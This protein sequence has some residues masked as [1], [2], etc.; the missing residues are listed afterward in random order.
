M[1]IDVE[2]WKPFRIDSLFTIIKGRRLTKED[3]EPGTTPFITATMENNGL[4]ALIGLPPFCPGNSLSVVYNGNGVSTAFYQPEPFFPCDDVNCFVPNK[5]TEFNQNIALFIAT[6]I[7]RERYRFSYGRK[8]TLD[9]MKAQEIKLPVD[10]MGKPDWSFMN[11]YIQ[12]LGIKRVLTSVKETKLVDPFLNSTN[13]K[14]FKLGKIFKCFASKNTN[15]DELEAGSTPYVSRTAAN[16]SVAAFVNPE[17]RKPYKGCCISIGCESAF[18]AY[19]DKPFLTGNKIYRL[20]SDKLNKFNGIFICTIINNDHYKWSYGRG[21]FL[22]KVKDD[23][24]K[25]PEK[26]G[27]PDWE[28][29]TDFIK[30]LPYSDRI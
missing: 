8:W 15:S 6:I 9:L 10:S 17:S 1:T 16:N 27:E 13:W 5:A 29:M 4:T 2:S 22:D 11:D 12:G 20:Y 14:V 21:F 18:A 25:L 3:M 30:S 19:Q 28:G 23:E 7:H 26:N 24:I